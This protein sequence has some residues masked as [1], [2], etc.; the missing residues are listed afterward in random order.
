MKIDEMMKDKR[1]RKLDVVKL[2]ITYLKEIQ[3]IIIF[4]L[5][6]SAN[7]NNKSRVFSLNIWFN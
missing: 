4:T 3:Y 5:F 1:Y 2:R 6:L 7:L